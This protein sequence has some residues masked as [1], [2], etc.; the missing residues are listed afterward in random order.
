MTC[1][2]KILEK[3]RKSIEMSSGGSLLRRRRRRRGWRDVEESRLRVRDISQIREVLRQI[4]IPLGLNFT[5]VRL[6]LVLRVDAVHHL[7]A[8]ADDLSEGSEAHAIQ[9]GVVA[10]V[11]EHLRCSAV[12]AGRREHQ[13]APLV[14]NLDGVILDSRL[15]PLRGDLRG[16]GN[17][18]L[19]HEA[20]NDTEEPGVLEQTVLDDL[21]EALR[22]K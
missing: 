12:G 17:A 11:D 9:V 14:A 1:A 18:E 16:S 3:A 6:L 13:R 22:S 19:C 8:I 20:G 21:V 4:L 5:L 15:S 2:K 10:E 7:H